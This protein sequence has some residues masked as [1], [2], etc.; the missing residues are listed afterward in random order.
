MPPPEPGP[1]EGGP[2]TPSGSPIFKRLRLGSCANCGAT[3]VGSITNVGSPFFG[4]DQ[5]SSTSTSSAVVS[6]LCGCSESLIESRRPANKDLK[7]DGGST[8]LS[9]ADLSGAAVI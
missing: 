2:G 6:I 4:L 9:S 1:D 7:A 5:I 8:S 3:T